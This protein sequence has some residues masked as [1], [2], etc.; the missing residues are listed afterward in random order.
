MISKWQ[1]TVTVALMTSMWFVGAGCSQDESGS[2]EPKDDALDGGST[3]AGDDAASDEPANAHAGDLV[4]DPSRVA[5]IDLEIS[6]G[7]LTIL[8]ADA[9]KAFST[10]DFTYVSARLTFDG[11]VYEQAGLR[12]KGNSSLAMAQGDAFPFKLDMN[13]YVSEQRL[14]GLTKINLH[15]NVNQPAAMN[16]YLSYGAFREFGVAA[17]RTGWADI[18]L[19]GQSLGLYTLVE[20]VN[21]KMLDR[22]Y[23]DG[24]ADL[25]KPEPPAGS[26]GYLGDAI[27]DFTDVG[28]EADND[29]DHATFLRMVKTIDEADVS[30][31]DAVIDVESV[32][33][34]FAGNVALGN[35]DTYVSMS[36]NYY[37]FEATPGR[38]VMLPWDMNLSQGATTAVCPSELRNGGIGGAGGAR[39]GG[40]F[41]PANIP[42]APEG[43]MPPEGGFMPPEGG[44][45]R[46]G[47]GGVPTMGGPGGLG[48]GSGGAP[49]HD[50]LMADATYLARYLEVLR[51]FLSGPGSA[52]TLNARI[53][54]VVDVLGARI[55]SDAVGD[56]RDTI[57][58]RVSALESALTTT[59]TTACPLASAGAAPP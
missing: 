23:D 54:A 14:D 21:D 55:S 41:D 11:V 44:F 37:L 29:T 28:Y 36:H 39:G 32:L 2:G 35:W 8:R 53:D 43:F 17:S 45:A 10:Q 40:A 15:N 30:T 16:E 5:T 56:L 47:D 46:P 38:M 22:W 25:Y 34:Y 27:G 31:W 24:S 12:V 18:T 20:Q 19:N 49:L 7:D 3:A 57:A 9:E 1:R 48:L 26:L 6:D 58:S 13:R 42:E 51:S 33:A 50:G 52:A 59:T 4:F